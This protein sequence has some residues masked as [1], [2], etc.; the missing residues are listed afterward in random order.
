MKFAC[1]PSSGIRTDTFDSWSQHGLRTL[2]VPPSSMTADAPK[3]A[4]PLALLKRALPAIASVIEAAICQLMRLI[5]NFAELLP[6][7]LLTAPHDTE[8]VHFQSTAAIPPSVNGAA[9]LCDPFLLPRLL[10]FFEASLQY[11]SAALHAASVLLRMQGQ[12]NMDADFALRIQVI[13]LTICRRYFP[14]IMK[15]ELQEFVCIAPR[16]LASIPSAIEL[17]QLVGIA[18]ENVDEAIQQLLGGTAGAD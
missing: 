16:S 15:S 12:A 5:S 10:D 3:R 2:T 18:Y 9:L 4:D 13:L 1:R 14:R 7:I 8:R 17:H 6:S 11:R